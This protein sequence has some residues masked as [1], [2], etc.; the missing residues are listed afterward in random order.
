MSKTLKDR[1]DSPVR[2]RLDSERRWA[3]GPRG[4]R[5]VRESRRPLAEYRDSF[6]D[7]ERYEGGW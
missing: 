6:L 4:K 2:E 3:R 7:E 5:Q 1:K